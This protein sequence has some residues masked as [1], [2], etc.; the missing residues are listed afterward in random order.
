MAFEQP[1]DLFRALR[2]PPPH[3]EPEKDP[4]HRLVHREHLRVVALAAPSQDRI[5]DHPQGLAGFRRRDHGGFR[6]APAVNQ[7][8]KTSLRDFLL[9]DKAKNLRQLGDGLPGELD[10]EGRLLSR[11]ATVAEGI[12]RSFEGPRAFAEAVVIFPDPVQ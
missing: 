2:V 12:D 6:P 4:V 7:V 9:L 10:P 5:S 11:P 1:P 3:G 8:V